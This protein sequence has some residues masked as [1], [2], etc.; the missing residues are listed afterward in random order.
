MK[1]FSPSDIQRLFNIIDYR[2]ARVVADILGKDFLTFEDKS[3]LRKNGFN[4]EKQLKNIPPYWQAFLFGRLS[5]IL[6]PSQLLTLNYTDLEDYVKDEQYPKLTRRE[7]AE[8]DTAATRTYGYIKGMGNRIR[9]TLSNAISE[10]ELKTITQERELDDLD[11]LKREMELGV[12]KRRSTQSIISNLGHQLND[13]NRDWGRIVETEMQN[14]YLFGKAQTIMQDHGVEAKVYKE[15]FPGACAHCIKLYTTAGIGSKPRIFKLSSLIAN[16]DNIG[17]K[18]RDWKAVLGPVHPFCF[19]SQYITIS[20]L[21]GQKYIK[22]IKVGDLV[23]THK[24]RYKPVT[25]LYFRD[26]PSNFKHGVYNI[27]FYLETDCIEKGYYED[28]LHYITGNHNVFVNG[29]LKEVRHIKEG[30]LLTLKKGMKV[31]VSKVEPVVI[32]GWNP[33]LYNFEVADDH[34]YFANGVA[35][36]NCRCELRYI[37]NGYVWDEETQSFQPPKNYERK[38]ERQSK[39]KITVGSKVFEV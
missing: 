17:V 10:E 2:M 27:F 29:E 32:E 5:S 18:V 38:V 14:I 7:K 20:V 6:S 11:V 35:V 15:V 4:I 8:Y 30:D 37:P 34:S 28:G 39:V 9:E 24:N 23:L 36:S 33:T 22:D 12:I 31:K 13:W 1:I 25:R 21:G 16:G 3:L 26:Y 19:A